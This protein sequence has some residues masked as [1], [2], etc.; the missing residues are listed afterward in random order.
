[1]R[2]GVVMGSNGTT[3]DNAPPSAGSD[4]LRIALETTGT[5]IAVPSALISAEVSISSR[6]RYLGGHLAFTASPSQDGGCVADV[7]AF[8]VST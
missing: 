2:L 1:M 3:W 5:V 7:F 4:R 8:N 6:K